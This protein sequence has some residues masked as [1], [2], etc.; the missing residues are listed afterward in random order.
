MLAAVPVAAAMLLLAASYLVDSILLMLLCLCAA[1]LALRL[2]QSRGS[3]ARAPSRAEQVTL[4]IWTAYDGAQY[5]PTLLGELANADDL[6][7]EAT[8]IGFDVWSKSRPQPEYK[9]HVTVD[10]DQDKWIP[11]WIEN[12]K[13]W[14]HIRATRM[15]DWM[16][17]ISTPSP[18]RHQVQALT[19]GDPVGL[20][21][22]AGRPELKGKGATLI[23]P[24]EDGA[25]LVQPH[26]MNQQQ[27]CAM[28]NVGARV[29][30]HGLSTAA[31]NGKYGEVVN[32]LPNGRVAVRVD[33][34]DEPIS[35]KP[36]CT[37]VM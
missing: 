35:F 31:Y 30:L 1:A 11:R 21:N 6:Q 29:E 17:L 20:L 19:A 3:T 8:Q 25:W 26:L 10:D 2:R 14:T 32:V 9:A 24:H 27:E 23:N 33:E 18:P 37:R 22:V 4:N 15:T 28:P 34:H 7:V 5:I 12:V 36:T 13:L 16:G